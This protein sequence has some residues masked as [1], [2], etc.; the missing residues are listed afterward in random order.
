MAP[1]LLTNWWD[2]VGLNY[3]GSQKYDLYC[4]EIGSEAT[5]LALYSNFAANPE[6]LE[7]AYKNTVRI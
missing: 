2:I 3:D 4:K 1:P 5:Y 6:P 7:E